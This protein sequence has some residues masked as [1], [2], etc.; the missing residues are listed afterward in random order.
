M[1]NLGRGLYRL[2][3]ISDP[4]KVVA[5]VNGVHLKGYVMPRKVTVCSYS[6]VTV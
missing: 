1:A 4:S 2:E 6:S 3:D 5:R